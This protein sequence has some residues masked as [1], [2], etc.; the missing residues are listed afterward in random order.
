VIR[1][2]GSEEWSDLD[3]PT[4]PSSGSW[5]FTNSGD[6]DL[7][8]WVGRTVEIGFKY[9]GSATDGADTWE[10]RNVSLTLNKTSSI[11]ASIDDNDDSFLVEVWGNNILAPEGSHIY[12]LNGREVNGIGVQRGIYIVNK[13]SFTKAVKVMVK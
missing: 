1:E 4:W 7:T 13:P 6:I 8:H 9:G 11:S 12:D 5:T 10:V 2:V 3:V